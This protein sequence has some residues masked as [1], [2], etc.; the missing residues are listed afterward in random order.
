MDRTFLLRLS[1][2]LAEKLKKLSKR[3]HRSMAGLIRWLILQHWLETMAS[4]ESQEEELCPDEH[5]SP[6]ARSTPNSN[7]S[8]TWENQD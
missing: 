4:E 1:K 5:H 3:E 8:P 2:D 6:D 7:R